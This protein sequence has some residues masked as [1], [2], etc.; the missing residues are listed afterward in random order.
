MKFNWQKA[1]DYK[2][3][4]YRKMDGIA[5]ITIN[6]PDVRNAFRPETVIEMYDA[7]SDAREDQTIGVILLTGA[8]PDK[9]GK[10]AFCSGGDQRIRGDKGYI[11][12]DGVPRLNVLDLQKL[13]RSI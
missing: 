10:Y 6:R 13:I 5:K 1:G 8:G 4:I 11:G 12:K 2:D 3:I 9:D 7:F